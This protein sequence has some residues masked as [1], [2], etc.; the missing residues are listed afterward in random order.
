MPPSADSSGSPWQWLQQRASLIAET[1]SGDDWSQLMMQ[2]CDVIFERGQVIGD[3]PLTIATKTRQLTTRALLLT[4]GCRQVAPEISGLTAIPYE[5]PASILQIARLP[6]SVAIIGSSPPHLA[7]AQ[8]LRRGGVTVHLITGHAQLLSQEDQDVSHWM[9]AQLVAEGVALH[10]NSAVASVHPSAGATVVSLAGT[11][12]SAEALVVAGPSYPNIVNLGLAD[13]FEG[14]RPLEVN[15]FLQ[16]RHPRIFASGTVL[17]GYD[18]AAIARQ[19]AHI[20]VENAL[21]WQRRPMDYRLLPYD[22]PTHPAVARVGLTEA[23]ARQRYPEQDLLIHRQSLYQLPKAQWREAITGF[24][25][26]IAHRRGSL[27]GC[28]GIG[29]EAPEW[30]QTAAWLMQQKIPWSRIAQLPVVPHSFGA[31]IQQA[32]E[33]WE[34]DRWQPGHWRRDWGDN[35]CN[36]RRSR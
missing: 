14:D 27:L 19:E 23:Q 2:G 9:T 35:W 36:W 13:W 17:G 33:V 32:S 15:A 12:V 5:T 30:I 24:C 26:V 1:L 29:P 22:F 18:A 7:L 34:R 6:E 3:R 21:F 10:L 20:A 4:T 28:H 25:K 8:L 16:T 31:L 11:D